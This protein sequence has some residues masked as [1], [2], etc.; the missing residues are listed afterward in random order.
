[1]VD[2]STYHL[3]ALTRVPGLG[4]QRI[5]KLI[6]TFGSPEAVF[7]MPTEETARIVGVKPARA[8]AAF[9]NFELVDRELAFAERHRIRIVTFLD[10]AYPPL[11]RHIPDFPPVLFVRGAFDLGAARYLSV[12]GTRK[13]TPYGREAVHALVEGLQGA[14]PVVVSGMAYGVDIEAHKA[15]LKAGLPTVAVM[16]TAFTS[17]YPDAHRAYAEQIEAGGALISEFWSYEPT[18]K[19]FF[20]RRNR[21]VAGMSMATVVVESGIK[22]GAMLTARMAFDYNR[23]VF[24]VP[25]R[26]TDTYSQGCLKLIEEGVARIYT[27]PSAL[28]QWL[29]WDRTPPPAPETPVQ[30]RLFTELSPQEQKIVDVLEQTGAEH[31]DIIAIETGMPVS[32][33]SRLLMMME[34]NGVI[35][36]L[37]GKKFKLA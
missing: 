19:N 24:A 12:V 16:G 8:L 15:A 11:L 36:S 1:M 14:H 4:G 37:P 6:R 20:V 21:I 9:E 29:D 2:T 7:E 34:L 25:G 3:M 28:A 27:S 33:V 18:D 32:E 22:G 26:V 10:D 13:I 35:E 23:E 31:L 17:I 5:K 30:T